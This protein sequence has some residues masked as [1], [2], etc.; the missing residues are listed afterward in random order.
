MIKY[1]LIDSIKK[2]YLKIKFR[3]RININWFGILCA[4]FVAEVSFSG[5]C[6]RIFQLGVIKCD[7]ISSPI[8]LSCKWINFSAL[9]SDTMPL[10]MINTFIDA[11]DR[12]KFWFDASYSALFVLGRNQKLSTYIVNGALLCCNINEFRWRILNRINMS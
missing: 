6:F 7:M 10:K 12:L 2:K 9:T 1:N 4:S 5:R 8:C 11:F 3:H